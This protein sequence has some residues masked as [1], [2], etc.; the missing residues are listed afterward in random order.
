MPGARW[1]D[2]E[3]TLGKLARMKRMFALVLCAAFGLSIARAGDAKVEVAFAKDQ[4]TKP[5]DEFSADVPKIYA[6]FRSTGTKK[7]D[8]LKGVWIAD[9]V[10]DA[11]PKGTK[12]D[13]ASLTADKDNFFGAFSL[14]KPTKGWPVGQYRV[15]I[16]Q[17]EKLATTGKFKIEGKGAG[18]DDDDKDDA[19]E[20]ETDKD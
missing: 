15:E 18:E 3:R 19:K 14:T 20:K 13:E 8:V 11:A 10:G 9:D 6:F 5:T 12:I 16:Y 1:F 17:G 7:G 4:E 2:A